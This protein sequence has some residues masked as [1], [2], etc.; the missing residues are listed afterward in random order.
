M[1]SSNITIEGL[2]YEIPDQIV[3]SEQIEEEI[4]ATMQR[5]KLP[6]GLLKSLT[7][8]KERRVWPEGTTPSEIGVRVARK[9]IEATD[10]PG[11]N[12]GCIINTSV[13]RNYIEPSVAC[14][15]QGSLELSPECLNFDVS[16]ACLGFFT[17][18]Q[19]LTLMI[20]SGQ[21]KYGLIVNGETSGKLLNSTIARLKKRNVTP[22]I[23][24]RN[25]AAL[26][27]GSGAAAMILGHKNYSRTNHLVNG[28]VN[29]SDTR[30]SRLCLGRIDQMEADSTEIMK[31]GI[32][33]ARKTW[34]IAGSRLPNWKDD[35]IDLYIPHQ[36]SLKNIQELS[37]A[38]GL[39]LEKQHLSFMNY[40]NIGPASVPI[41]L[42]MAEENKRLKQGDHVALL[43]IGSGLNCSM[44]SLTW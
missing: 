39:E 1:L 34:S 31:Q 25:F 36:V 23:Y 8:I 12:I 13:S 6:K 16:N 43:G 17:A 15:I 3:T 37:Q 20:E 42:K 29:L 18:I 26:T 33:L 24:R 35:N 44:M 40:G 10:I 2:E 21:I 11:S 27:L 41:T 19:I 28:I 32:K 22:E 9:V 38:L 7:G 14:L 30:H 4:S 5:L